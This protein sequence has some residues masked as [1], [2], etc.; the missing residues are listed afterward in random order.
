LRFAF[1]WRDLRRRGLVD[2][3]RSTFDAAELIRA[4]VPVQMVHFCAV[5][6]LQTKFGAEPLHL[7]GPKIAVV[8]TGF[9]IVP[10][11]G[12][13]AEPQLRGTGLRNAHVVLLYILWLIFAIDYAKH[14]AEPSGLWRL[15]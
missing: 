2:V 13:T 3:C 12:M 1:S 7:G 8:L 5:I 10:A 6:A 14:P 4:F 15:W 11:A 9:S